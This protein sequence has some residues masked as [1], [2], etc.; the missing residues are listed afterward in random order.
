[1]IRLVAIGFNLVPGSLAQAMPLVVSDR[2]VGQTVKKP[3]AKELQGPPAWHADH[4]GSHDECPTCWPSCVPELR[5]RP[6][7]SGDKSRQGNIRLL[8]ALLTRTHQ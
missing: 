4:A 8:C 5:P 2:I 3:D 7:H 6:Q 1:M